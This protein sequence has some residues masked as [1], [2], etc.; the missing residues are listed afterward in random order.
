MEAI[1]II[2]VLLL[3]EYFVM[4]AGYPYTPL[5]EHGALLQG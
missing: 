1:L 4:F 5:L 2:T 3:H